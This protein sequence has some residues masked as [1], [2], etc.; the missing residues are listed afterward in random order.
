MHKDLPT[1]QNSLAK[2]ISDILYRSP[3]NLL[4]VVDTQTT[5]LYQYVLGRGMD[6]YILDKDLASNP[7]YRNIL[8]FE[9]DIDKVAEEEEQHV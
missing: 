8:L 7:S 6:N 2:F 3:D 9:E 5:P 4:F 1:L